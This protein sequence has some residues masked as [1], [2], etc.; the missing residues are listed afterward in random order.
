ML[1]N[2]ERKKEKKGWVGAMDSFLSNYW[3][4]EMSVRLPGLPQCTP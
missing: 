3:Q 2:I 1:G 4:T